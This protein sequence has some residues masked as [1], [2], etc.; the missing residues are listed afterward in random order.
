VQGVFGKPRL[1]WCA[2]SNILY[3]T[4]YPERCLFKERENESSEEH[5]FNN[6]VFGENWRRKSDDQSLE[7][8]PGKYTFRLGL[9]MT[10]QNQ[11]TGLAISRLVQFEV[12]KTQ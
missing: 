1:S 8:R 9:S 2:K 11:R 5:I 12:I 6:I 10:P 3:Y 7:L 4:L